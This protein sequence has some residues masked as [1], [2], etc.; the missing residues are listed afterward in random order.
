MAIAA[1]KAKETIVR[2]RHPEEEVV[3]VRSNLFGN[4]NTGDQIFRRGDYWITGVIS[5]P[6]RSRFWLSILESAPNRITSG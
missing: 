1:T 2:Q 5:R 6:A 3:K 4:A